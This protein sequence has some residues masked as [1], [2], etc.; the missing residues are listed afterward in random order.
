MNE[1][2]E[3]VAR[4]IASNREIFPLGDNR[5][6]LGGSDAEVLART[7]IEA[8]REPTEAM[9]DAVSATDKMWR[10][11]NSTQVYQAMIDGAL[12]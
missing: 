10:E 1:M 2:V 4:A 12:K 11:L 8:M 5:E 3:K 9:Y 7:A 6:Y